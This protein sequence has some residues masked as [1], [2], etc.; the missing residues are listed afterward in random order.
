MVGE[1]EAACQTALLE[2]SWALHGGMD[3][4]GHVFG[5]LGVIHVDLL[6]GQGLKV[7]SLPGYGD[8]AAGNRGWTMPDYEW[9]WNNGYPQE[10]A[11]FIDCMRTGKTPTENGHDGKAVLEIML[12]C[13][14]SA[15]EGRRI[16]LPYTPPA[17]IEVPVDLWLRSKKG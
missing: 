3:S 1:R 13:Y 5:T 10:D 7:H 9:N 2:S 12:A 6:R 16:E 15:A 14:A 17:D 8:Y 11:H 4:Y